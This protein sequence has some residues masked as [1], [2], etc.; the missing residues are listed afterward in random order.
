L[1]A[2]ECA[3]ATAD[4]GLGLDHADGLFGD[5]VRERDGEVGGEPQ[6]FGFAGL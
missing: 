4:F 3:E 1:G 6:E 2:G 5:V